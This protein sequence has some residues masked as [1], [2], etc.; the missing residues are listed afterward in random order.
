MSGSVVVLESRPPTFNRLAAVSML[1]FVAIRSGMVRFG[2]VGSDGRTSKPLPSI[3]IGPAP[4]G[5]S[6]T[7]G[8]PDGAMNG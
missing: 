2:G 3:V 8:A 4:D 5:M 7:T 6:T 1:A